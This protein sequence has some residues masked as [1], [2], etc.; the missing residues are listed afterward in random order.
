[1]FSAPILIIGLPLSAVWSSGGHVLIGI[2]VL[3]LLLALGLFGYGGGRVG[4]ATTVKNSS[5]CCGCSC[6]VLVLLLP[7]T[8]LAFWSVGGVAAA[9]LALPASI[10]LTWVPTLAQSARQ[11]L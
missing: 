7:I 6:V 3:G 11:L 4:P 2:G 1:M 9:A 5:S 8:G 10:G